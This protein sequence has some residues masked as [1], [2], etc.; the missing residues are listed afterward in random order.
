IVCEKPIVLV[1]SMVVNRKSKIGSRRL[2]FMKSLLYM[3]SKKFTLTDE[4][5]LTHHESRISKE[6]L[7]GSSL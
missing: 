6:Q 4:S 5:R 7:E 2:S 3:R 1:I